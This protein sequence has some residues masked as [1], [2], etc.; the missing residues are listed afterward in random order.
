[1]IEE[2]IDTAKEF[3]GNN[4]FMQDYTIAGGILDWIGE[5]TN[6]VKAEDET[7]QVIATHKNDVSKNIY[8]HMFDFEKYTDRELGLM[9]GITLVN[10]AH[11]K[12]QYE[13]VAM[14]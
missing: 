13:G 8:W 2:V 7:L 12:Q 11:V 3:I 6:K 5:A 4:S 14:A 10:L 9:V 1:M